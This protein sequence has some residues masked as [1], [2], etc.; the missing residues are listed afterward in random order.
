M[1]YTFYDLDKV[2]ITMYRLECGVCSFVEVSDYEDEIFGD[3]YESKGSGE[4]C[5]VF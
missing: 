3:A 1:E 2:G 5:V 4:F